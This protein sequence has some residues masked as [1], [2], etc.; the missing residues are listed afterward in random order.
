MVTK[1]QYR[2]GNQKFRE[3]HMLHNI[4][5]A[6]PVCL[7]KPFSELHKTSVQKGVDLCNVHIN[8]KISTEGILSH[9]FGHR[10]V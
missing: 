10:I 7:H 4:P 9:C 3:T 2:E 6:S 5:N 8:V 1:I